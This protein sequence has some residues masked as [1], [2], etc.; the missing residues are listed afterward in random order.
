MSKVSHVFHHHIKPASRMLFWFILGGIIGLFFFAS[1]VFIFYQQS[2][3]DRV[4]PDVMVNNVDFSGKTQA[5]VQTYFQEKNAQISGTT[6]QLRYNDQV[7]TTSAQ[8]LQ[9]GYDADLLAQQAMSVG[10]STDL[11]ANAS[12]LFQA[13]VDTLHL[14]ASY[15][16]N[17][18]VLL[19]LV[20]P[21]AKQINK[22]PVNAS[23]SFDG[24]RVKT[25]TLSQNG[26]Q[27]DMNKLKQ[28]IAAN[29]PYLFITKPKVITLA[30][31][32]ATVQP[33]I[34]T[35]SVNNYGIKEL[36]ATGTSIFFGSIPT[37]IDNIKLAASRLNGILVPP[38][39]VFSFDQ[40]VGDISAANG[41]EQA[42]V[43]S[44][45]RTVLGDGGGV[46][47]V[48]TTMFRAILNAGLPILERHAHDYEVE[49]YTEDAPLGMD[50]AIYQ[51]T[52]DLKFKNDTAHYILIQSVYTP[53]ED[54][55]TFN[56]YGTKD[57]RT[58]SISQPVISN[59]SPAPPALYQ[60]DPTLANGTVKQ[61]D[62]AAPGATSIFTRTVTQNG[63]VIINDT[64]KSVYR[65][66]QAVYLRGTKT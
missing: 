12:L 52:D 36:I 59:Q 45:G 20:E 26:T 32:V 66:W 29:I 27:V 4:Y 21:M 34:T 11:I 5:Q 40:S 14:P 42:Y 10:R 50:A 60:D 46:C 9:M 58:V 13:Y 28:Q 47:Q 65:P 63:K 62:F 19:S 30:L 18:S 1:F 6:I 51:P 41:Y 15:T 24:T 39:Q 64:F 56:F 2:Y 31:P 55:L 49:Y 8:A 16:S 22:A 43:I 61:V 57:G 48:S 54:R 25:F 17:D 53:S 3:H 38:G 23:F 44:N 7:A 37:R 35:D 33:K